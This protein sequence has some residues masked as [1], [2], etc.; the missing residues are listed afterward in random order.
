[1]AKTAFFLSQNM[2]KFELYEHNDELVNIY[3]RIFYELW[4]FA[5]YAN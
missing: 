2:P 1:M 3:Y 4:T 5:D